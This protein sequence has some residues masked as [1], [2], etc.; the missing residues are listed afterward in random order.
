MPSAIPKTCCSPGVNAVRMAAASSDPS[1]DP[2][3]WSRRSAVGRDG[4]HSHAFAHNLASG[5]TSAVTVIPCRSMSANADSGLGS[6]VTTTFAPTDIAPRMPG[7]A[8]GKLC[9]AG[10]DTR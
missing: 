6:A 1:L 9:P 8:N 7:H 10:S 5:G 3:T 4:S 2:P